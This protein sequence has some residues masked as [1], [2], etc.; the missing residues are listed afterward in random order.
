MSTREPITLV[1]LDLP[2][3]S[4][5]YGTAPCTAAIPTTGTRKC[6]NSIRT[7]QDRENF[8]RSVLTL[9]LMRPTPGNPYDAIPNVMSVSTTPAQVTPGQGMGV[10]ASVNVTCGDHPSGDGWVDKYLATRGYDPFK[11]G[12]FW[13]KF[14]AR[15]PSIEGVPM[16]ILRGYVGDALEDMRTEQY[17]V[18]GMTVGPDGVRIVA[19]DALS[20]C[21]PKKAQCPVP[22]TGKL[23]ADF[24][25]GTFTADPAG[26]GAA[27]YPA[28][29]YVCLSNKEIVAFTRTGDVFTVGTRGAFG[30]AA[31]DHDEGATVQLCQ[32]YDGV[33]VADIV[34]DLLVT[35]TP[36]IDPAWCDLPAWQAD[37]DSYIGHLYQTAVAA[38]ASVATLMNEICEQAGVSVWADAAS[39]SIQFRSLRPV[40]PSATVYDSDHVFGLASQ[41]Q[42]DLRMSSVLTYYAMANAVEKLDKEPN[43]RAQELTV[44]PDAD[45]DYDGFPAFK[46]NYSRWINI[47]N[48]AAAARLNDMQLGR[49]RDP[50]RRL[51][52]SLFATHPAPAAL[53]EGIYISGFSLQDDTGAMTNVPA[54]VT[55]ITPGEDG[56]A[57]EAQELHF[58]D[59]FVPGSDRAVYIDA[60]KF[61]VNLRALYDTLYGSVPTAAT[62]TFYLSP[63][64]WIGST[65]AGAYALECLSADWPGD[66]TVVLVI[67][68]DG[69]SQSRVLGAGGKGGDGTATLGT[70]GGPAIHATRALL[71]YNWGVIGGGGDGGD[72]ALAAGAPVGGGG[73]AGFNAVVAGV[74]RGGPA[75]AGWSTV[76]AEPGNG[77]TGGA[78]GVDEWVGGF[79]GQPGH[80][81]GDDGD[82]I[83]G[84]G[85]ITFI[86]TGTIVGDQT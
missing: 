56:N 20:F 79:D 67:G 55:S 74:R 33:S 83:N 59:S 21:D 41:D 24:T 77:D 5:T 73:G 8:T 10:R 37:A 65:S 49:F 27:E 50:P 58:A 7:C 44:D 54:I 69:S 1:E 30:S 36:G 48:R 29:G 15:F 18:T 76:Q 16:R 2:V 3:C 81:L 19:K 28:S 39:N 14:R 45:L 32:V 12:T 46:K 23:S 35:F 57:Y 31:S 61:N 34:Y 86:E 6:F 11:V 42:P 78:G 9:R 75:G 43:F 84:V 38:P 85:F 72:G 71:V 51:A 52:F 80:D 62:I 82:A 68:A 64:V 70:I 53:G 13:P 47:D 4:L 25:T 66:A 60:D 22:T 40:S 26:V 63:G 17:F